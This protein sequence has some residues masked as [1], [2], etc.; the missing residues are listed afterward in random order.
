MIWSILLTQHSM[1]HHSF[2]IGINGKTSGMLNTSASNCSSIHPTTD[3]FTGVHLE[4]SL[5][6]VFVKNVKLCIELKPN[7]ILCEFKSSHKC[8]LT[9]EQNKCKEY[10]FDNLVS[11]VSIHDAYSTIQKVKYIQ[12]EGN[13]T[14]MA[15]LYC[16]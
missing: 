13:W 2:T 8:C 3:F 16:Q 1:L 6:L 11:C 9:F 7:Y 10:W 4:N 5:K 12:N 14:A 15:S